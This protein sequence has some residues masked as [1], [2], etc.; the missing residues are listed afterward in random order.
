MIAGFL[1]SS[2][3][4]GDV[5]T[6]TGT[7]FTGAFAVGFNGTPATTFNVTT[8]TR[9]AAIV[10]GGATTGPITVTTVGGTRTSATSLT[11]VTVVSARLTVRLAT[12][13][14]TLGKTIRATGVLSPASLAGTAVRL[15]VR[16]WRSGEWTT[17]K[18]A[19]VGTK[20]GGGYAWTYRPSRRG[21][22]RIRAAIAATAAHSAAQSRTV[23]FTVR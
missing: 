6:L 23:A 3:A 21:R 2:A 15:K 8:G 22:Y 16:A 17:A 5:V 20:A 19:V 11:I 12:T 14:A 13:S 7:G 18:T 10:P 9:L 4:I 1:P